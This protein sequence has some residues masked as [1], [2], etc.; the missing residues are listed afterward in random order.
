MI[1]S[2]S[3]GWDSQTRARRVGGSIQ[4]LSPSEGR[5]QDPIGRARKTPGSRNGQ[6]FNASLRTLVLGKKS[7]EEGSLEIT[8]AKRVI[9]RAKNSAV[10]AYGAQRHL[11]GQGTPPKARV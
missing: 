3:L 1:S 8:E 2:G 10:V 5:N 4:E 7:M 6:G 11:R 9:T